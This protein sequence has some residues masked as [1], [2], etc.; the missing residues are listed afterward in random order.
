MKKI[1]FTSVLLAV[2]LL[3]SAQERD[4][5]WADLLLKEVNGIRAEQQLPLLELDEILSAAAFDQA[6]YCS[7]L[8]RLVHTH[9][10]SKK[11]NVTQRVLY[12]EGLHGRLEENLS[13][14]AYGSKEALEPNGL[15][16]E[17]DT[18]QK[19]VKAIAAAWL[20]DEKSSKLNVLDPQFTTLGLSVIVS[21]EV[22]HLFCAVFGSEPY[23]PL[24]TEK[25][26]L[27]NHGIEP[28]DKQKCSKFLERFP[29]VPQLFSDVIKI[30]GN[31]V[32]FEYH[33]LPFVEEPLSDASDAVAI[34]WVD[35]RQYKCDRGVQ[36]FP[37][38]I[39]KGYLQKPL[40]KSYL[41][42]QN[43]ADSIGELHV[44]LGEVPSF[45]SK[46]T[47]EPNLILV[48][49]GVHCA[50]VP[51]NKI[52]SKKTEQVPI[53]FA[54][55]GESAATEFQWKDSIQFNIPL[56]P[57]GWDSL[58]KAKLE[59][60]K[61]NFTIASSNLVLQVSPIHQESLQTTEDE[62]LNKTLVAW[63]SLQSF[64][65]NTY[66][67]LEMAE[68]NEEE[69]IE[70][71][72]EAQKEDEKLKTFLH[73][74]NEL[75]YAVKGEAKVELKAET[76]EQLNLY[77]FFL[78]NNQIEPALFVQSKLL[79]KVRAGEL[80]AKELPQA[81]PGQKSNTLAVINNQIVLE[82]IMGAKN[83]GGNP[84]YLAFF[85][86]YLINKRHSEVAFNYNV[87]KL[88]YWSNNQAEIRDME[89][90]LSD[91]RKI[92]SDQ[93]TP[94][95]YARAMMNYSL[96]AV[97][98]F[99][100]KGDFDKR[101]KSFTELMKWQAK[102]NLNSNEKLNLAKMLC[103]QD[104]FS[105][106]IQLLKSEVQ[107][108]KVDQETLFY[109][110]QIAIYDKAQ[111][112]DSQYVDLMEKASKLYPSVFCQFFTTKVNGKQSLENVQLKNLYCTTCN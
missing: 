26:S 108:E 14:I 71:L 103:Y 6:E 18:D 106:A 96:L 45:Y 29:S 98:Y 80:S 24:G 68:L 56:F 23:K 105:Y 101:R 46:A 5:Y 59:L 34:D 73:R 8:G 99:Y 51:F 81:D 95:K 77:R 37:G 100:D 30:K 107:G 97:D 84:I 31:E 109:F 58:N 19:L 61:I 17:I 42:G 86:L 3:F 36:L 50:T 110:L 85:E 39:A 89:G 79:N 15:R 40:K 20:E 7:E 27:K 48:K 11:E 63:D 28:F 43:L 75:Q 88:E 82:S 112:T 4:A 60:E 49:D 13:Q 47:T 9:D 35:Q 41:L 54:V 32:Y 16:E 22:D 67:Q 12:Y 104:Q 78:E 90:W 64:I 52:E 102:G 10:N 2:S 62:A 33:S 55:A 21:D 93:I 1:F 74:L 38:S 44:K 111:V 92:P 83:Y 65:E 91:F 25:L 94:E 66:Y 53:E 70:F 57:N 69:K 76:A 87:A 72:K